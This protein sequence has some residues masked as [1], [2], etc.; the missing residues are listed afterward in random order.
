VCVYVR[1]KNVADTI[2]ISFYVPLVHPKVCFLCG[3]FFL[4]GLACSVFSCVDLR[5]CVHKCTCGE[6][7]CQDVQSTLRPSRAC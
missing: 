1:A 2:Y 5:V 7:I 6:C 4:Y 3:V